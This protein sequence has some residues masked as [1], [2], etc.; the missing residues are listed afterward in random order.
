MRLFAVLAKE[1]ERRLGDFNPQNFA[2]TAWA[3]ATLGQADTLLIA[4]LAQEA[5]VAQ[6]CSSGSRCGMP[7]LIAT[8]QCAEVAARTLTGVVI[9]HAAMDAWERRK[10]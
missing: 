4:E 10:Q 3:F 8:S 9:W 2:N 7:E 6:T 1:A 5:R